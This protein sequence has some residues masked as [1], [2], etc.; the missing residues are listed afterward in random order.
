MDYSEIKN[1][2]LEGMD[3]VFTIM[4]TDKVNL[5]LFDKNNIPHDVYD[6]LPVK[7]YLPPIPLVGKFIPAVVKE[8]EPEMGVQYD[9]KVT[10][11][12]KQLIEAEIPRLTEEDLDFLTKA[13]IEFRG[14]RYIINR[15]LPK[16][17]VADE[18]QFYD[19]YC[20]QDKKSL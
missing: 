11:P 8:E 17:L 3:E 4:F 19:F 16:T 20:M 5:L 10:F 6:E 18:W 13:V 2:F 9:T 12:T 7:A 15:V 14:W 1:A